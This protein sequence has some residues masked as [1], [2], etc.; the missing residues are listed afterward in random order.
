MK[1]TILLSFAVVATLFANAQNIVTGAGGAVVKTTDGGQTWTDVKPFDGST[2]DVIGISKSSANNWVI[3]QYKAGSGTINYIQRTTDGGAN[4]TPIATNLNNT[5]SGFG[6]IMH[7][8][9]DNNKLL[10]LTSAISANSNGMWWTNGLDTAYR[11]LSFKT[12][13]GTSKYNY[14]ITK[15]NATTAF[16]IANTS[17]TP[18]LRSSSKIEKYT[19]STTTPTYATTYEHNSIKAV[20]RVNASTLI[21]VTNKLGAKFGAAYK[22][23]DNG[24]T[25]AAMTLPNVT[26]TT[27]LTDVAVSPNGLNVIVVGKN[28]VATSKD[29]GETWTKV[30]FAQGILPTA[31]TSWTFETIA[32]ADDNTIV[33]GANDGETANTGWF[34]LRSTDGG[35]T[36]APVQTAASG[37]YTDLTAT[38]LERRGTAGYNSIYFATPLVGYAVYGRYDQSKKYEILK[39]T[40]AGA[41]WT[42]IQ[43]AAGA[44]PAAGQ[45]K[46][47]NHIGGN[48]NTL[49]VNS[50]ADNITNL[51]QID[52]TGGTVAAASIV[53]KYT[54]KQLRSVYRKSATELFAIE[55]A[56]NDGTTGG[57]YAS[58]DGGITWTLKSGTQIKGYTYT[59]IGDGF[60][61]GP[62]GRYCN[63]NADFSNLTRIPLI[64]HYGGEL[65][66]LDV[67]SGTNNLFA[68]GEK[69]GIFKSTDAGL[70]FTYIGKPEFEGITFT[71]LDFVDANTGYVVGYNSANKGV[72]VSTTDGGT[73][74]KKIEFSVVKKLNDVSF[75]N[76]LQGLA[77]GDGGTIIGTTDGGATW[78]SKSPA[79]LTDNMLKVVCDEAISLTGTP[80]VLTALS[81]NSLSNIHV[82]ATNNE[83]NVNSPAG[84]VISVYNLVGVLEVTKVATAAMEK[85]TMSSGVKLV[86]V[87]N[88]GRAETFKVIVR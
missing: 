76:A 30:T 72:V 82:Y 42:T 3:S 84:S 41:T 55:S 38:N 16:A 67:I 74:W 66:D 45:V 58:A 73:T 71:A 47:Y 80:E 44:K 50:T 51:W 59:V 29:A 70:N 57:I 13:S 6:E 61:G 14:G 52:V 56:K 87:L 54:A 40:D 10:L 64:G 60:I 63:A 79:G 49:I 24:A 48:E 7:F 15:Q 11:N 88:N 32:F 1:K 22:S 78:I 81:Q 8:G 34:A 62:T 35:T 86:K 25:W 19:Y 39:T 69:A 75:Y 28:Y 46:I 43:W 68:I 26:S 23:T 36:F 83:L 9:A 77:V 21:A 4:Y 53:S 31:L 2:M 65:V 85:L 27:I 33:I 17:S 20:A 18:Y 37:T 12:N 5:L